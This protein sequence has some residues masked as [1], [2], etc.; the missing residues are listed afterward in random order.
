MAF[1]LV[2]L[3]TGEDGQSHFE[4]GSVELPK[5][6]GTAHR[7][8]SWGATKVSFEESPAGST[9]DWHCAPVRQYVITLSGTLEFETRLGETFTLAPGT[10]L[11]A[12]D[13]EGGGHKWR[14]TD[15]QPWRRVYVGL[16]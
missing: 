7:S 14:L 3:Y 16:A 13:T 8:Q 1:A 10:I 2:R 6:E 12:E 15:D 5:L 11:L 9:L 4:Q